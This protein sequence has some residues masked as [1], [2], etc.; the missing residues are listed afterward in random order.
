[1]NK[2]LNILINLNGNIF[3]AH[4]FIYFVLVIFTDTYRK[5]KFQPCGIARRQLQTKPKLILAVWLHMAARLRGLIDK[6]SFQTS[7]TLDPQC[8]FCILTF[9][10]TIATFERMIGNP[11]QAPKPTPNYLPTGPLAPFLS[12]FL[13][14]DFSHIVLSTPQISQ[15]MLPN[16]S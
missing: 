3:R 7:P 9:V 15:S 1:M 5:N 11:H 10:V 12:H 4:I 8:I 16:V 6:S 13:L 2:I 14:L